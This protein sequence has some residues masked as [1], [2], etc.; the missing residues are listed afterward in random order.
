MFLFV[1][2]A[3]VAAQVALG[4]SSDSDPSHWAG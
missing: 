2:I 1:F 4:A 3:V